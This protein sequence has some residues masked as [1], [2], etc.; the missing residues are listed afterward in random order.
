MGFDWSGQLSLRSWRSGRGVPVGARRFGT[1]AFRAG[2]ALV[3]LV[4]P[5]SGDDPELMA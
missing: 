2:A 1:F 3:V 5:C 4:V